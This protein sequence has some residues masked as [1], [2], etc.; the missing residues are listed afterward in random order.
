MKA[1]IGQDCNSNTDCESGNCAPGNVTK[2]TCVLSVSTAAGEKP[3]LV[4][5]QTI[6]TISKY[7]T[8]SNSLWSGADFRFFLFSS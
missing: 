8:L 4:V 7:L 2:P 1:H 6:Q 5:Q 3:S